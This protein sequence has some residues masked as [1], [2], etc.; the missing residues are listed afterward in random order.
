MRKNLK[1]PKKEKA[2]T[3]KIAFVISPLGEPRSD[4]RNRADQILKHV[5]EPILSECD[6]KA[7][8]ADKIS[9][10]GIITSQIID[11]VVGDP[12]VIAD[13]TGHNPNV[14]YELAVRHS[15]KK[16]IVQLIKKG[17][18][19]PFDVSTTRT[20][21]IDHHDL[22]SVEE[23]KRELKKQI[24]AVE[25]DP[26]KVDSPISIA[27]DL[28]SLK[29]S[30]DPESKTLA[31][32]RAMV[33]QISIAVNDIGDKIEDIV[34]PNW[35]LRRPGEEF[36]HIIVPQEQRFVDWEELV[37]SAREA[38]KKAETVSRKKRKK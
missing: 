20:I 7:L 27:I 9:E 16:P 6:Y 1:N 31:E 30:G 3:E 2:H 36:S 33:Q 38:R 17:E 34:R 26:T 10:P 25:K 35:I 13:L 32:L 8:R 24:R 15:T 23:A 21:Q 12:L 5:I 29:Q 11:H 37:K 18:K 22:D 19:I 14:F 28:Q 4:I